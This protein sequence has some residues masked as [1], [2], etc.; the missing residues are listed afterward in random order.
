MEKEALSLDSSLYKVMSH[1][2]RLAILNLLKRGEISVENL[3]KGVRVRKANLSQ[4][5]SILRSHN[6]VR[7]RK[8]GQKVFYRLAKSE[9]DSEATNRKNWSLQDFKELG[10][11]LALVML[12]VSPIAVLSGG[13]HEGKQ[14]ILTQVRELLPYEHLNHEHILT[15]VLSLVFWVALIYMLLSLTKGLLRH[16]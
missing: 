2:T 9:I 14:G 11:L 3:N 1:P 16:K 7:F 8:E 13:V 15:A 10:W 5:L 12:I 4:H 6:L